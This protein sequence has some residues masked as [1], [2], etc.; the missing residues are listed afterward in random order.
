MYGKESIHITAIILVIFLLKTFA[1]LIQ[2]R[3]HLLTRLTVTCSDLRRCKVFICIPV[4]TSPT[5]QVTTTRPVV[6]LFFSLFMCSPVTAIHKE[7][8]MAELSGFTIQNV[9]METAGVIIDHTSQSPKINLSV[10]EEFKK[11]PGAFR[12]KK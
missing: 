8:Y 11:I 7:L 1:A 4:I 6:L 10:H 9:T 12:G 2:T 5:P 3:V